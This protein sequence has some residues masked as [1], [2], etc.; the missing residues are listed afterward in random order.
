MDP[1]PL[2]EDREELYKYHDV[3]R[4]TA[5][6]TPLFFHLFQEF[7]VDPILSCLNESTIQELRIKKRQQWGSNR[8]RFREHNVRCLAVA[9]PVIRFGQM[10]ISS[11]RG[12]ERE[13]DGRTEIVI[14]ALPRLPLSHPS[15]SNTISSP[16]FSSSLIAYGMLFQLRA[17]MLG[18]QT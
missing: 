1:P 12:R 9:A 7:P 16:S 5:L 11:K 15:S 3:A 18:C 10:C 2:L 17:G 6:A 13:T 14:F 4:Q 8:K